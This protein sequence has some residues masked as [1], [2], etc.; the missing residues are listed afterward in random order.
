MT[1]KKLRE[2]LT[3]IDGVTAYRWTSLVEIVKCINKSK[4][5]KKKWADSFKQDRPEHYPLDLTDINTWSTYDGCFSL[6]YC[7][8]GKKLVCYAVI[9][10]GESYRGNRTT[11]RFTAKIILPLRFIRKIREYI[12]DSFDEYLD[13]EHK[14]YLKQKEDKWISDLRTKILNK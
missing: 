10:N 11:Q 6:K 1:D 13:R 3:L 14:S 12:M 2:I 5:V 9:Y 4:V 8:E 7:I